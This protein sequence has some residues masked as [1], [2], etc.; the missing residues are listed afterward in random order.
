[1][2]RKIT[3]KQIEKTFVVL[4]K[5][6]LEIRRTNGKFAMSKF[7][8]RCGTDANTPTACKNLGYINDTG[9]GKGH[10]KYVFNI[11]VIEPIHA[12]RLIEERRR[13]ANTYKR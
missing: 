2:K 13:M 1:M 5:M 3:Q 11:E 9:D 10:P 6:Q 4:E 8:H 12:R 7:I